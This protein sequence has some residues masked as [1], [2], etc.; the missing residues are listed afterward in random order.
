MSASAYVKQL[1]H[2]QINE[3]SALGTFK[4]HV[5]GMLIIQE[6]G[7]EPT[8]KQ[9]GR[10]AVGLRCRR[11]CRQRHSAPHHAA[12][13]RGLSHAPRNDR[14]DFADA[15]NA[16]LSWIETQDISPSDAARVLTTALVGLILGI[17]RSRGS[18]AR[19]GGQIIAEIIVK[20]LR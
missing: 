3:S 14:R 19:E 17:A 12:N 18:D 7:M 10:A 16:L 1:Q 11:G 20:S 8:L 13:G 4:G 6:S 2:L 9:W 5:A 15:A